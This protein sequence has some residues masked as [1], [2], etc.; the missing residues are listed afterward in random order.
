MT[1]FYFPQ[2]ATVKVLCPY[3]VLFMQVLATNIDI[4]LS[5]ILKQHFIIHTVLYF[6]YSNLPI[7]M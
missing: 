1:S 5:F 3:R 6:L 2:V 7:T 4:C